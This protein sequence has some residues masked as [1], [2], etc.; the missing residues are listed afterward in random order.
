MFVRKFFNCKFIFNSLYH[1]IVFRK[2]RVALKK[3][4]E[5]E[6]VFDV[7]LFVLVAQPCLTL[8]DPHVLEPAR[9]LC[10]WNS[11]DKI[12]EV[13]SHS[14]LQGIFLTQALNLGLLHCR[15]ILYHLNYQEANLL[16]FIFFLHSWTSLNTSFLI[17][18]KG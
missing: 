16:Q 17:I 9:L 3:D 2:W 4:I 6:L 10:P 7:C 15:Q 1:I 5:K 18:Q 13:G 12:I 14:L 8:C 11:P